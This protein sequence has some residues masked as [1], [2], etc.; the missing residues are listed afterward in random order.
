MN[1]NKIRVVKEKRIE[2]Q[3]SKLYKWPEYRKLEFEESEHC[4]KVETEV[5]LFHQSLQFL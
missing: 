4:R 3:Y 2:E 5:V 1:N